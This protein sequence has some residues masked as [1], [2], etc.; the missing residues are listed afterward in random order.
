RHRQLVRMLP[1]RMAN[2]HAWYGP[3]AA[4]HQDPSSSAGRTVFAT[5]PSQASKS[6]TDSLGWYA[7]SSVCRHPTGRAGFPTTIVSGSTDLATT[8][9]A[10]TTAPRPIVTPGSIVAPVAIQA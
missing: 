8:A 1:P 9:P 4:D 3:R 10:P 6:A 5:G 2:Q 7:N